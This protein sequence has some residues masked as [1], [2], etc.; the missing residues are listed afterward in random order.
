MAPL[1]AI[2][3]AAAVLTDPSLTGERASL[4][5]SLVPAAL[6]NPTALDTVLSYL[7][8]AAAPDSVQVMEAITEEIGPVIALD[9]APSK[10]QIGPDFPT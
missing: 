2:H 9:V 3:F 7:L 5:Q 6:N 1:L 8:I 10:A 4:I